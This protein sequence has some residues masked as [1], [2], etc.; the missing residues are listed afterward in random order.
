MTTQP[1]VPV[2]R[3]EVHG[4]VVG[5]TEE[6]EVSIE[7]PPML[8]KAHEAVD[9]LAHITAQTAMALRRRAAATDA[10]VPPA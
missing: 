3:T 10:Q 4:V 8:L 5:F 7:S 1:P 9:V 2:S 6:G